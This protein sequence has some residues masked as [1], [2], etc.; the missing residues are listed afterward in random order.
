M[1]NSPSFSTFMAFLIAVLLLVTVHSAH[2]GDVIDDELLSGPWTG[3]V[4]GFLGRKSVSENDWPNVDSQRSAGVIADFGKKSWPV[5]IAVDLLFAADDYK[6]DGIEE[7]AGTAEI[8]LGV[9]KVFDLDNTSISPYIGGGLA[10]VS[11]SLEYESAGQ[12]V[13]DDDFAF[14]GWVGAGAYYAITPSLNL[15]LDVRYSKAEVNLF[16]EDR[17]TG[18]WIAGVSIGYHW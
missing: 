17:D 18:G 4:S 1:K 14:G 12:T 11:G 5:S 9:R 6:H 2:A 8:H 10:L 3:N 15:G 7:T 13:D 16:D